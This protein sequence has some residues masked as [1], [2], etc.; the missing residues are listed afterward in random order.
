MKLAGGDGWKDHS[1]WDMGKLDG[2]YFQL[3]LQMLD[4]SIVTYLVV[5]SRHRMVLSCVLFGD[6]VGL[7]VAAADL[8]QKK[9]LRQAL[10]L[11]S[12]G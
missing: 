10:T 7:F 9:E 8:G 4:V 6:F 2:T 5:A 1:D 12:Q 11:L 3:D